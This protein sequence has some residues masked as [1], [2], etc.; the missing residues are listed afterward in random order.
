LLEARAEMR[1]S[2][3]QSLAELDRLREA[4]ADS[5]AEISERVRRAVGER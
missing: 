5:L 1:A 2:D 4:L 3:R